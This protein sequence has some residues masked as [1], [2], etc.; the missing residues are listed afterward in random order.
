[1][2]I[3]MPSRASWRMTRMTSPTSSGSSALVG[4][5]NHRQVRNRHHRCDHHEGTCSSEAI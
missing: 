2:T 3:V 5:S 1:M 4:S